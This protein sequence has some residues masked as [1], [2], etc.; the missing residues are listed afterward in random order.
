MDIAKGRRGDGEMTNN[1]TFEEI[2]SLQKEIAAKLEEINISKTE[3]DTLGE[4]HRDALLKISARLR[5]D[6]ARLRDL[7]QRLGF[8]LDMIGERN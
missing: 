6:M 8:K 4:I 7:H 3:L 1:Q 5:E 2:Q